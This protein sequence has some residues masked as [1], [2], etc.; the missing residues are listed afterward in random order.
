MLRR[1]LA[2]LVGSVALMVAPAA[3]ADGEPCFNDTDC[4]GAECGG[5]VCNWFKGHPAPVGRMAFTCNPAG[6]QSRGSDGWCET[7]DNCK[8][9]AQGAKCVAPYCTFTKASDAPAGTGGTGTGGSPTTA[10]TGTATAGTATAGTGSTTPPAAE[11]SS[12]CNVASP[13]STGGGIALALGVIGL[14]AA[15]ARRRR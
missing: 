4:P 5:A 6:S 10:G 7:D 13:V 15:F 8:C 12:G 2:S 14:G 11:E 9:K 1:S 3:F